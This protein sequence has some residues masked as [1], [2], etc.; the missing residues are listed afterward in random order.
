MISAPAR[1]AARAIRLAALASVVIPLAAGAATMP[2]ASPSARPTATAS[3]R[4]AAAAPSSTPAASEPGGADVGH[5]VAPPGWRAPAT[6]LPGLAAG[7]GY[8]APTRV[9][10]FT[11]NLNVVETETSIEPQIVQSRRQLVRLGWQIRSDRKYPCAPGYRAQLFEYAHAYRGWRL[12]GEAL[13]MG[14]EGGLRSVVL[15]YTRPYPSPADPA[16]TRALDR[17][18]GTAS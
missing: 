12:D 8:L 7:T 11:P 13:L 14:R 18:C 10:G 17:F 15:T 1:L 4:P 3:A 5:L 16:A 2:S 9:S 6:Q